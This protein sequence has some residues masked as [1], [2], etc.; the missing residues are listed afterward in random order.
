MP[1]S[2]PDVKRLQFDF[3]V[4]SISRLDHMAEKTGARTRAELLRVALKAYEWLLLKAELGN[5]LS[6]SAEDLRAVTGLVADSPTR[7]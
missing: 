3:S 2:D 5:D 1:K 6:I 7:D 4:A